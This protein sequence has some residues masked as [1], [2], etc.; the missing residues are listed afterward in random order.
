[1]I[2][3]DT[4]LG[5][6]ELGPLVFVSDLAVDKFADSSGRSLAI[7]RSW[8]HGVTPWLTLPTVIGTGSFAP[9]SISRSS[10]SWPRE[11]SSSA[12]L[13]RILFLGEIEDADQ[14]PR[15][16]GFQAQAE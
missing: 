6:P 3:E 10:P 12:R 7:R 13:L 5:M 14:E 9:T 11:C 16:R 1:M 4:A 2:S 8:K 15:G